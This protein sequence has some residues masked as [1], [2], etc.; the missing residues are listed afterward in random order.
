M[1]LNQAR[2]EIDKIDNEI[3]ELVAKRLSVAKEIAKIKKSNNLPVENKA[4]EEEV[5]K[6]AIN[7]LKAKGFDDEKFAKELFAVI[8]QKSKEIQKEEQ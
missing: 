3:I 7:N 5:L 2:E 8:M 1:E 4:R 6:N